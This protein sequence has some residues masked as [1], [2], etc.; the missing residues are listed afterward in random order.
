MIKIGDEAFYL[1][2]NAIDKVVSSDDM[3]SQEL[4]ETKTKELKD[5]KGNLVQTEIIT[6]KYTKGKE[7]DGSK[8]DM[9]RMMVES[10]LKE[11]IDDDL[12]VERGLNNS[13]IE[14]KIAFNTLRELGILKNKK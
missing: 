10:V 3:Q 11:D 1:D 6:T 12:G 9:I 5:A 4:T 2:I 13:S 8:Y 14:F 7:I